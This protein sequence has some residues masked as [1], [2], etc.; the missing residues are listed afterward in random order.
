[1]STPVQG[2]IEKKRTSSAGLA[3]GLVK[4]FRPV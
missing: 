3:F 2:V 4:H 1:M